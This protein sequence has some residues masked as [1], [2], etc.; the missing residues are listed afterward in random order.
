L[1]IEHS[2]AQDKSIN[3]MSFEELNDS[4]QFRPKP[5]LVYFHTD[6]CQY[7]KK[8][9]RTAFRDLDVVTVLHSNYYAVKMDAEA[10]EE[11]K[12]GGDTFRNKEVGLKRNPTHEIA[13][14]L[15][16]RDNRSFSLP[17][18]ILLDENF[19]VRQRVFEYVSPN[20]MKA[21]LRN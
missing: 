4:L 13:L 18:L 17:V 8:M 9:D 14:A 3:W 1:V 15:G 2:Y 12:F 16:S 10:T 21:L 7:C 6:W 20:K 5:V 11:I 19:K